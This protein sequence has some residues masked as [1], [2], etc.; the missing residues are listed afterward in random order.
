M[1]AETRAFFV[2]IIGL[3]TVLAGSIGTVAAQDFSDIGCIE[4][5]SIPSYTGVLW[6][7]R[8]VGTAKIEIALDAGGAPAKVLVQSPHIS[9]TNWLTSSFKRSSFLPICGGRTIH[10]TFVY[11]LEG[12]QQDKP[13]NRITIKH[14]G[15][16]E[17]TAHPPKL[18]EIVN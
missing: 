4:E 13:D 14:P 18:P 6:Q 11:K 8:I 5:M 12:D 7:A 2:R 3:A 16:F 15:T 17:I 1:T 10:L 9:M